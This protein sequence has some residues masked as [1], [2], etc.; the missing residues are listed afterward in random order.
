MQKKVI[1]TDLSVVQ[2][3]EK[4]YESALRSQENAEKMIVD[5]NSMAAKITSMLNAAGAEFLKS[6][7]RYQEIEELSKQLGVEPSSVLKNKKET[8]SIAIKEIDSYIK[9][10]QSGKVKI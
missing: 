4:Q 1:Q 9:Q 5:Y 7:A 3:F 10:L 8:V 6:N 2:D